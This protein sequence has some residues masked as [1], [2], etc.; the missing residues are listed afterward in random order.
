MCHDL[1]F[2]YVLLIGDEAPTIKIISHFIYVEKSFCRIFYYEK[3]Y[4]SKSSE[5]RGFP[6]RP[7]MMVVITSFSWILVL[8]K[9][10]NLC[11]RDDYAPLQSSSYETMVDT[12]E[13]FLFN[14][15]PTRSLIWIVA[16]KYEQCENWWLKIIL[17]LANQRFSYFVTTPTLISDHDY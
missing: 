3:P 15:I 10:G 17:D 12:T 1:E 16:T 14:P 4:R 2:R 13:L 11:C 5:V 8:P 7:T 6:A 9:I